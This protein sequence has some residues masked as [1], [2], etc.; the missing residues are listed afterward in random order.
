MYSRTRSRSH[1]HS[2]FQSHHS[3]EFSH[4]DGFFSVVSCSVA[5]SDPIRFSFVRFQFHL[6]IIYE[7]CM[8]SNIHLNVSQPYWDWCDKRIYIFFGA[9]A[10]AAVVFVFYSVFYTFSLACCCYF[11][12]GVLVLNAVLTESGRREK[13]QIKRETKGEIKKEIAKSSERTRERER[14]SEKGALEKEGA[15]NL[16]YGSKE[17]CF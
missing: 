2:Q 5:A 7:L 6:I 1:S 8:E 3:Y 14:E 12:Y 17:N 13:G 4:F 15:P 11:Y 16:S 9:A 10:A